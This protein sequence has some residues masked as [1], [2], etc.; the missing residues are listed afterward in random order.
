MPW[1]GGRSLGCSVIDQAAALRHP[2][3]SNPQ[4]AIQNRKSKI[5]NRKSKIE[6]PI[7]PTNLSLSATAC[8]RLD[9]P[10][11]LAFAREAGYRG[12]EL[13]RLRTDS[14]PVLQPA[15][16]TTVRGWISASGLT[17]T[18]LNVRDLTGCRSDTDTHDPDYNLHQ[19][20]W[21]MHLARA[22]GLD[23]VNLRC[24]PS[25]SATL[26]ELIPLIQA[27]RERVPDIAVNV[28][29]RPGSCLCSAA[30][31]Q[32]V[33]EAC[34]DGIRILVD[35]A[36]LLVTDQDVPAFVEAC[37]PRIGLVHL[38]DAKAGKPVPLGEGA[39][40]LAALVQALADVSD[41]RPLV[42]NPDG[43]LATSSSTE[44][45]LQA[46]INARQRVEEA[47]ATTR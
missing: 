2:P 44:R 27:L 30:D 14:A 20:T 39:L 6:N 37:T 38:G 35:T 42:I 41:D 4:S 26:G 25:T 17:L 36:A 19:V 5:E 28:A 16:L 34:D 12:I 18:G 24:G 10:G 22:L 11:A 45:F 47:W 31:C 13:F 32:R 21:D 3:S 43:A 9:L 29:C 33:L 46:A 7:S 40:P 15:S 8:P 23:A 1:R